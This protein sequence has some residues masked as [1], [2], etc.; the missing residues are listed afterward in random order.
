MQY[1]VPRINLPEHELWLSVWDQDR[2]GR[3]QFLGEVRLQL[4]KLDLTDIK[5][6]W[7]PLQKKVVL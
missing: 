3:N 1:K 6:H 5:E 2:L 4:H 7:Y